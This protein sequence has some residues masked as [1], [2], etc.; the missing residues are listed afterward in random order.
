MS[1]T[2][3]ATPERLGCEDLQ[4]FIDANR[5]E[6]TIIPL[7]R[8]TSTV[9]EAAE[10]LGVKTD[11]IIKS[12]VFRLKEEAVLV[13]NNG[14]ARV[15]RKKIATFL[16]VG[17]NRVKFA[18]PEQAL[19]LTGYVVGSMPPFGHKK[20]L[21]TLLDTTVTNLDLIYGGGGG[22]DAMMRLTPNELLRITGAEVLE[23]SE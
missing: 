6:A 14:L 4:R 18:N 20:K 11:H 1:Q 22:I 21:R 10:V 8:H 7:G 16:G 19:E 9:A 3:A 15:D 17:R 2:D 13:I 12:L 23:L 5:I